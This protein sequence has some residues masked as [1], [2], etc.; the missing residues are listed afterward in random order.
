M[1]FYESAKGKLGK[2]L[3]WGATQAEADAAELRCADITERERGKLPSLF[4][5]FLKNGEMPKS[6]EKFKKIE[7]QDGLFAFK[8]FQIRLLGTYLDRLTFGICHCVRKKRDKYS[9]AD[10]KKAQAKKEAMKK[11]W[12]REHP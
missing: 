3:F 1:P 4:M 8:S 6:K 7:K 9:D 10:L 11:E 2:I 5:P 12:E